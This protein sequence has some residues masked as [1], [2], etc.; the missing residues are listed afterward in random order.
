MWLWLWWWLGCLSLPGLILV[1]QPIDDSIAVCDVVD[2]GEE[3]FN[4]IPE[5]DAMTI[6]IVA[7][8]VL[9]V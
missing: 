8:D 6:D 3:L 2:A 4:V 1:P 9:D 5:D 7:D